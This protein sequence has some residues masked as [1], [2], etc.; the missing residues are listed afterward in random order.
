MRS[1]LHIL[2]LV[3]VLAGAAPTALASHVLGPEAEGPVM[4]WVGRL[5]GLA[6][7]GV[8]IKAGH[9]DVRAGGCTLALRHP[10]VAACEG[11]VAAGGV[12]VCPTG[13]ACPDA[14][15]IATAGELKLP[16]RAGTD[17]GGDGDPAKAALRDARVL[18]QR[19]F[20]LMDIEGVRTAL[21]P[22]LDRRDIAADTLADVLVVLASSGA[23]PQVLAA[24][25]TAR[26]APMS[27]DLR[28]AVAVSALLG[29]RLG[30]AVLGRLVTGETACAVVG[31]VE[32]LEVAHH[33]AV[34]GPLAGQ[35][36]R[37][38]PECFR[39][40]ELEA[41]VYAAARDYD[42][43]KRSVAAALARFPK[44]PRRVRL[45][46]L[47]MAV[48]ERKL[49]LIAH[50]EKRLA[51]GDRSPGLFSAMFSYYVR[52]GVMP[53]RL[54]SWVARAEADPGDDVAALVGGV[55]LHYDKQFAR[56]NTLVER[57]A[58]TFVEEPRVYIYQAM[59]WFNLG[60]AVKAEAFIA[61]A[62]DLKAAD[63]DVYYCIGEIFRD[64]DRKR[65]LHALDI[66]LHMTA[67][68]GNVPSRKQ[69]RV[70]AMRDAIRACQRDETPAPC[71]GPFE[72]AF[73]SARAQLEE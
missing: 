73:G 47:H 2:T 64:T 56:S 14:A 30:A 26:F 4:R 25:S 61:A 38:D 5:A 68:G 16:W 33:H 32:G 22:L 27:R 31:F 72:H 35:L 40:W 54:A 8:D 19:R 3:A 15:S 20:A 53:D 51:G 6:V 23:A 12:V 62:D 41:E 65:A 45:E 9:V 59:N 52:D 58:P 44:H 67:V 18:A 11:A 46:E 69:G 1:G 21:L 66:Y 29:P 28:A 39:A 60:D 57:A 13:E 43:A 10:S 34:A 37:A 36:R 71:P 55:L 42:A 17:D 24:L 63:P 49:D 7:D 70:Y 48:E 50:Y